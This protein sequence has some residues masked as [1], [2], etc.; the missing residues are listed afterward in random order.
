MTNEEFEQ[1]KEANTALFRECIERVLAEDRERTAATKARAFRSGGI[2]RLKTTVSEYVDGRAGRQGAAQFVIDEWPRITR[3]LSK[4]A[5]RMQRAVE[6]LALS[7][8][9]RVYMILAV[10]KKQR[11]G[12]VKG[13]RQGRRR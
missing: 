1:M 3:G 9:A 13:A 12:K 10:E 7:A 11:E 6:G 2:P 5:P 4:L 8:F